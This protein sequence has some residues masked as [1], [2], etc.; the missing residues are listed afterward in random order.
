MTRAYIS[1]WQEGKKFLFFMHRLQMTNRYE[2]R[3]KIEVMTANY[4]ITRD[5]VQDL[6]EPEGE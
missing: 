5:M 6:K 4:P 3:D 1:R 2:I